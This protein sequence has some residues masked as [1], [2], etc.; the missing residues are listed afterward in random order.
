MYK[1]L[2]FAQIFFQMKLGIAWSLF[3]PGNFRPYFLPYL[4]DVSFNVGMSCQKF[5]FNLGVLA[6]NLWGAA[7]LPPLR[8]GFP[9]AQEQSEGVLGKMGL[10]ML[11]S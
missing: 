2:I 6:Q 9:C 8:E 4:P 1:F 10:Q 11:R 7:F 3:S 5:I